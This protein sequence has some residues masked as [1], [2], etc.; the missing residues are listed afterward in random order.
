MNTD[1]RSYVLNLPGWELPRLDNLE[2]ALVEELAATA[3]AKRVGSES[4]EDAFSELLH[5]RLLKLV[6][7]AVNETI[8]YWLKG[9]GDGNDGNWPELSI[10]L[11]YLEHREITEPLTLIY[12]VDNGDDTRTEL[13]RTTL[14]A[15]MAR[16]LDD[17]DLPARLRGR[18]R[19]VADELR[20]LAQKLEAL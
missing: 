20:Q 1:R 4:L 12:C 9:L 2:F 3:R 6:E 8:E 13:N 16:F 19:V 5:Q 17:P 10:E 15:V 14:G 7:S 18:A 11:P